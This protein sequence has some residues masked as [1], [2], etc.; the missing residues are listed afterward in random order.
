M[1]NTTDGFSSQQKSQSLKLN[2]RDGTVECEF[3]PGKF[4]KIPNGIKINKASC[5]GTIS[6]DEK[7]TDMDEFIHSLA[8]YKMET[9]ILK[10]IPNGARVCVSQKLKTIID[11]CVK[12]NSITSWQNLFLFS[13]RILSVPDKR[14]KN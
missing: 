7:L 11:E 14:K 2:D 8:K 10:R 13:Y 9:K 4:F 1:N 6:N 5:K 3:C 12:D